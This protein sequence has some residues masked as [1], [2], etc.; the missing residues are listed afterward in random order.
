MPFDPLQFL[1]GA[2]EAKKQG[3]SDEDILKSLKKNVGSILE[4]TKTTPA[5]TPT[6]PA[7]T[8]PTPAVATQVTPAPTKAIGVPS[9]LEFLKKMPEAQKAGFTQEQVKGTLA[10]RIKSVGKQSRAI[11]MKKAEE[12]PEY[13]KKLAEQMLKEKTG[14][15]EEFFKGGLKGAGSTLA[16]GSELM[17]K[18]MKKITGVGD[19]SVGER[20]EALEKLLTPE[21]KMQKIG[22]MTEQIAEFFIPVGGVFKGAK[23][24]KDTITK[25]PKII[26]PVLKAIEK[27]PTLTKAAKQGAFFGAL[28]TIQEGELGQDAAIS[29]GIGAAGPLLAKP[30]QGLKNFFFQRTVPTTVTQSAKDIAKGLKIG[31]AVSETGVSLT[32]KGLM[33]SITKNIQKYGNQLDDAIEVSLKTSPGATYTMPGITKGIKDAILKNPKTLKTLKT[34]PIDVPKVGKVIDDVLG[35]YDDLYKG[36]QMTV[37]DLQALK[38]D[39]GMGLTKEFQKAVDA[40]MKAKPFTEK[41]LRGQIQKLIEKNVPEA[42]KL[43]Q[44]MAPLLEGLGRMKK[45]GSYSGYLTD[46]LAGGFMSGGP[47]Q[48]VENPKKFI[49]DFVTGIIVKRAGTSTAAKTSAGTLAKKAETILNKPAVIQGLK[50]FVSEYY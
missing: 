24:T 6:T 29:A 4:A 33:K 47:D 8:A 22:F 21:G 7:P 32:K 31:E 25:A 2:K 5:V 23:L 3:Y 1:K 16:S 45:K 17:Q 50:D 13:A 37:K 26:Q 38:V 9:P 34:T 11:Q 49:Q 12:D 41:S 46:L 18:T 42:Q 28:T 30:F 43:N 40:T 44:K 36:Q 19:E 27:S 35:A 39:L 48:L 14:G 10:E 15:V 20:P